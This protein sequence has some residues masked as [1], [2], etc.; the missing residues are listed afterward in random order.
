MI[1]DTDGNYIVSYN[2]GIYW[3]LYKFIDS[4]P[5][6]SFTI[7]PSNMISYILIDIDYLNENI[8]MVF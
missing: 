7:S 3:V 1:D 2:D 4:N 6:S 8:V 5:A